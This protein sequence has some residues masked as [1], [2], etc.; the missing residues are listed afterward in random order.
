MR[1]TNVEHVAAVVLVAMAVGAFAV[2]PGL[3]VDECA[4][5]SMI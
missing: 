5:A 4:P 1:S 3:G 2:G